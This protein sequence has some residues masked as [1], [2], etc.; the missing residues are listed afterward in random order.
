MTKII[1]Y[2]LNGI[3][4]AINKGLIQ[5][6]STVNSDIFCFQ[7]LK[8][9]KDQFDLTSFEKLQYAHFWH[10]AEKKGY[11]G[12][13]LLTKP[14]PNNIQIGCGVDKY[15]KEGRIIR[16][17]YEKFSLM[18]VYVPSG[19][20]GDER[21]AFKME[22]LDF[23][24]DYTTEIRSKIPN[25]IICGDFNICHEPI[26]IHNPIANA[27]SSGFL[28]EEREWLTKFLQ[29]GFT[30]SFRYLN[31][32]PHHYTWWSYRANAREKNLGWR[33]DYLMVSNNIKKYISKAYILPEV[34]HSDHCPAVL[35]IEL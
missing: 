12:V 29:T 15:D 11:S 3:R 8:A 32:E 24:I 19:T 2:N 10:S 16:V 22:F 27:N 28:P 18:N 33:I 17:D 13:G 25:L 5:W 7:E 20:S 21:Q 6:I 4:A 31:K 23:F 26:D 35:E 34:Y 30:D 1:S 9:N 14:T